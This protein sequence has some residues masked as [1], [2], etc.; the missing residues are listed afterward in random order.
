MLHF[1]EAVGAAQQLALS[2][3]PA[4]LLAQVVCRHVVGA[5]AQRCMVVTLNFKCMLSNIVN[6]HFFK[7]CSGPVMSKEIVH[8]D[9]RR[10]DFMATLL[11]GCRIKDNTALYLFLSL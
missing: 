2:Q 5:V 9:R 8:D 1:L 3:L 10:V 11:V 6:N 7:W 4:Q